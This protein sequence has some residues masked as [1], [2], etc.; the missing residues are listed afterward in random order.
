MIG[1]QLG[2]SRSDVLNS[3]LDGYYSPELTRWVKSAESVEELGRYASQLGRD[4]WQQHTL[5]IGI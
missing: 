5:R 3:I 2:L 1:A 4:T